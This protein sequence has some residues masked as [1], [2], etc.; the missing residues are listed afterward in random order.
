MNIFVTHP[1]AF[2]AAHDLDDL[3]LNKMITETAQLLS[4]AVRMRMPLDDIDPRFMKAAYPAHPCTRWVRESWGNWRW[5]VRYMDG[6]ADAWHKPHR[7]L[8]VRS[9]CTDLEMSLPL[10]EMT[11]HAVCTPGVNNVSVYTAYQQYLSAKWRNDKR[12]PRWTHNNSEP[13]WR[14]T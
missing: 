8:R 13:E 12:P 10:E 5:L 9:A 7:S 14:I 4:T 11:P 2:L 1:H 6:L 3:R